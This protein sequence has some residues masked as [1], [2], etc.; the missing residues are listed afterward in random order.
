MVQ[1]IR[2]TEMGFCMGVRRAVQIME[3]EASPENPVF[4]V[5]EIVHNP[6]SCVRSKRPA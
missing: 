2:A 4:S 1:I 6:T 3:A 5:G